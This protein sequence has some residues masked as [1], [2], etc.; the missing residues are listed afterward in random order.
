MQQGE[1]LLPAGLWRAGAPVSL[2]RCNLG[3]MTQVQDCS[4]GQKV[5]SLMA[6]SE[7]V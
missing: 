5:A 2:L 3:R 4:L 6:I 7:W 1:L